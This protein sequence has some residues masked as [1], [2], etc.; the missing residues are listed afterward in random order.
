MTNAYLYIYPYGYSNFVQTHTHIS[1]F[2]VVLYKML[3]EKPKA[4]IMQLLILRE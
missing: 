1:R 2:P 4:K 3:N